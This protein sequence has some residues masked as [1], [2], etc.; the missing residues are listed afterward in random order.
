MSLASGDGSVTLTT[1]RLPQL[2]R[3]IGIGAM[4]SFSSEVKEL[5]DERLFSEAR[6]KCSQTLVE[7]MPES[8]RLIAA[9]PKVELIPFLVFPSRVRG[10]PEGCYRSRGRR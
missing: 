6:P 5:P 9:S 2:E 4:K 3:L 7:K 1:L 10:A 8:V